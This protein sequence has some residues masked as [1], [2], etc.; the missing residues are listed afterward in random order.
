MANPH[1]PHPHSVAIYAQ[2]AII[3]SGK[4]IASRSSVCFGAFISAF[5]PIRGLSMIS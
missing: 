1:D 3:I 2:T 4:R 5:G